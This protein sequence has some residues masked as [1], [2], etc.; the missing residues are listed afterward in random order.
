M[1]KRGYYDVSGVD[2]LG[3]DDFDL[4]GDV[5]ILGAAA[6]ARRLPAPANRSV[7]VRPTQPT[8]S[9]RLP[10]GIDSGAAVAAGATATIT[11]TPVDAYRPEVLSVDSA[12]AAGFII[13][14]LRI[15]RKSQLVGGNPMPASSFSALSPLA[16]CQ[17]DTAQQTQPIVLIV[18]N[19]SGAALRFMATFFGTSVGS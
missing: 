13:S 14:D 12:I 10:M 2:I 8:N 5:D 16:G 3:E 18:Q 17:F 6:R 15:G 1:S 4:L 19:T 9:R 7:Q 11:I